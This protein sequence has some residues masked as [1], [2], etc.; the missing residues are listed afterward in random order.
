M[1]GRKKINKE[2]V[3]VGGLDDIDNILREIGEL[4]IEIENKNNAVDLEIKAMKEKTLEG[5]K[6]MMERI[7]VLADSIFAYTELNKTTIFDSDKKSYELN[8]GKIGYRKSTKTSIT[9]DTLKLLKDNGFEDGIRYKP[10]VNKEKLG[11]W[12]DAKLA[13]VKAK[14]IVEDTFFY[15]TEH[16][17][18]AEIE[19]TKVYKAV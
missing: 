1:G 14:K 11:E 6:P 2:L 10:E 17:K 12:D 5:M 16:E 9:R 4:E 19:K 7:K 13:V 15:E 3:H 18:I 8:F